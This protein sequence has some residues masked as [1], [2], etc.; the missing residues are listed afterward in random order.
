MAWRN[1]LDNF[2]SF[3]CSCPN[4]MTIIQVIGISLYNIYMVDS[5]HGVTPKKCVFFGNPSING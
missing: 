5:K 1:G 3:F 2:R 4:E